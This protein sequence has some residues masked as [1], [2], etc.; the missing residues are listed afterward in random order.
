MKTKIILFFIL[1]SCVANAQSPNWLW[2]KAAGGTG[3][4][5]FDVGQSVSTDAMG[6]I[7]VTGYFDS[8]T[9]TFGSITLT[10]TNSYNDIFIAKYDASGNVIWAKSAG[11]DSSD[12]SFGIASD[13]NG[14]VLITG[15]FN[16]PII[17]FGND[18]LKNTDSTGNS[19]DVFIVKYSP[20]GNPVWAKSAGGIYHDYGNSIAV[21]KN[22]N[23]LVT[24]VFQS[25]NIIFGNDTLNNGL[26]IFIAKYSSVG[27]ILWA[28]SA[29][30][31]SWCNAYGISTD[32]N[33]NVLITGSFYSP[34]AIFGSDTLIN[35]GNDDIF[36]VKY[37]AS[38]NPLWAKSAGGTSYDFGYSIS[39]D[40]SGNILL[41]G[42]FESPT[43][44]F[45]KT[46]LTNAFAGNGDFLMV[47]YSSSGNVLWARNAGGIGTDYG[48][49]VIADMKGNILAIG[50]FGSSSIV[51]GMDTLLSMGSDDILIVKYDSSGNV[52]WA[53][54]TG[55]MFVDQGSSISVDSGGGVV[56]TGFF[57]SVTIIF[58]NTTLTNTGGAEVFIAKL[59]SIAAIYEENNPSIINISP[60]PS[61]G[62][63]TLDVR[64][65]MAEAKQIE[66]YNTLEQ[67]IYSA[68]VSGH[69]SSV[70]DLSASPSG[71]YFLHI[72]SEGGSFAV[73]KIVKE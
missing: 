47:K 11:G 57:G 48:N 35:K 60:N 2:A 9:I 26:N 6:N 54:S 67:K 24:G 30:G 39:T 69:P 73:K 28:K 27:N 8:P 20:S 17:V 3:G 56:V 50:V 29:G 19:S 7:L 21:D 51:F 13:I 33:G 43:I 65:Q 70:I 59:N 40:N 25:P 15:S 64:G 38:G 55:G 12:Y 10:N 45:D 16:S 18:T 53:Q 61:S 63:F 58:G 46:V 36:I 34:I 49:G 41:T 31:F 1:F 42:I 32:V 72:T 4:P 5:N 44:T 37:D 68:S 23:V 52:L 71:I 14:N 66:I 62:M 22:G